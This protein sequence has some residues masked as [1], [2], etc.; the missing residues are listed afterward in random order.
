MKDWNLAKLPLGATIQDAAESLNTSTMQIALI[1]REDNTLVGVVTDGDIRRG[2]LAGRSLDSDVQTIMSTSFS[3][4][5]DDDDDSALLEKM[6]RLKLRQLPI[7]DMQG[8]LVGLKTLLQLVTPPKWDNW[9]VL[10]AGGLGSRLRPL[11]EN[12]PKPLLHIG[13]K[14]ILETIICQFVEQGFSN[15]YI[16]INYMGKMIQSYLGDGSQFGANIRYLEEKEKLGTGGALGLLPD[17]PTKPVFVMNGDLLT[18]IDFRKMLAFH[19]EQNS[20]ATMA[21]R[22]FDMQV[23][24]GVVGVENSMITNIEEKPHYQF[25]VNAGIYVLSPEVVSGIPNNRFLDMPTLFQGLLKDQKKTAAFPIH[26][27]WMD[28]G[29][30]QDF[31]Q[32]NSDYCFH[33]APRDES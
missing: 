8:K 12:C 10:M 7:L 13:D 24:F 31:D 22:T 9:V 19:S 14:P 20:C 28:I 32:A 4:G 27:Y 30:K 18:N 26:E 3:I 17:K 1:V 15:F 16:S 29:Q 21:V 6:K 25:F 5:H 2:L 23:P 33:F 11:T